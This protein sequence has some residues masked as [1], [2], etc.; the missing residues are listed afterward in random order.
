MTNQRFNTGGCFGVGKWP[1]GKLIDHSEQVGHSFTR[2]QR[3]HKIDVEA[4]ETTRGWVTGGNGCFCM[5]VNF[6]S[7]AIVAFLEPS[8]DVFLES[9]PH[10]SLSYS[11]LSI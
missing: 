7:L 2:W 5:A 11:T 8:F 6:C 1:P 3:S 9:M 10:K 4:Q